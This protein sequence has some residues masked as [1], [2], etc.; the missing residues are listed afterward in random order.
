MC[1]EAVIDIRE[2][3]YNFYLIIYAMRKENDKVVPKDV[4]KDNGAPL[5]NSLS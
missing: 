4:S 3:L 1:V 2:E 5:F